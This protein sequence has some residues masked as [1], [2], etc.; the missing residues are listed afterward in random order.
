MTHQPTY[1][2]PPVKRRKR[3]HD[4]EQTAVLPVPRH[5]RPDL[6]SLQDQIGNAAVQRLLAGQV[7]PAA[8]ALPALQRQEGMA[9]P[10][11][12]G[13]VTVEEPTVDTYDVAGTT[14]A[15]VAKQLDPKEWGRC[16][17][18]YDYSYETAANGRV[19]KVDVTLHLT[20]RLPRWQGEGYDQASAAAKEEWQR[21]LTA[22]ETH[23]E[24]HADIARTWA[25][26]MQ[27]RLL[28]QRG[29]RVAQRYNQTMAAIKR[30]Q[31]EFDKKTKHGQNQGVSLD[32]SIK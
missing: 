25:A 20:I 24:G 29:G 30:A 4:D 27:T 21:M 6:V 18:N 23:E 16:T 8:A 9:T 3:R 12:Q 19:T 10:P 11:A 13:R 28:G 17:Y 5:G 15:A 2:R 22:L 31:D 1:A 14:L 26:T 32:R 7:V